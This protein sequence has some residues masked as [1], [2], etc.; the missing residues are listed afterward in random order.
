MGGG[1]GFLNNTDPRHPDPRI[2]ILQ[3]SRA[4]KYNGK[5]FSNNNFL[6]RLEM[7]NK[8]NQ[9]KTGENTNLF[10]VVIP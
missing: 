9:V 4:G 2:L 5:I 8:E 10:V 6:S 7:K 3:D 1:C